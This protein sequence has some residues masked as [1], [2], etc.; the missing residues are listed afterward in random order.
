MSK[1]SVVRGLSRAH[2][3]QRT[4]FTALEITKAKGSIPDIQYDLLEAVLEWP[5]ARYKDHANRLGIS[6]GT[7]KSRLSRGRNA[8]SKLLKDEPV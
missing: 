7:V 6:E 3:R 1:I 2:E 4:K 5:Q 8:L